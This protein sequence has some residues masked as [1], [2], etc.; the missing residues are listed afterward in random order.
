[1]VIRMRFSIIVVALNPGGKLNRTLESI[2]RQT[3]TDYEV[4]L[5]DGGSKD[6]SMDMWKRQA[7]KDAPSPG[8]RPVGTGASALYGEA[9]AGRV[10][11]FEEPDKGIYDAMNQAVSHARG[12]YILFLNC[13]D[14][15]ADERVLERTAEAIDRGRAERTTAIDRVRSTGKGRKPEAARSAAGRGNADAERNGEAAGAERMV[16]YGDTIGEKNGVVIAAAP[17]ITGF[18]CYRNI[19]C[20]QSCFYSADLCREKPYELEYKIRA[21]YDHFLWCFY[22]AGAKMIPLRFPVSSYEG[23]GYSESKENA[24]RDRQ[25]HKEITEQYMTKPA[26]LRYQL[27]MAL[28]LAPL[29][30][31]LAE[32]R[33][34][35]GV[36]HW[37]KESI[38]T[39]K[40]WFII[41]FILSLLEM[42]LMVWPIGWCREEETSFLAGEGSWILE[43]NYTDLSVCQEFRPQYNKLKSLGFVITAN[44]AEVIGGSVRILVTDENNVILAERELLYDQVVFDAYTD[45]ELDLLLSPR[46]S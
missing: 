10:R 32:N 39:R 18:T 2:F 25:E 12:E 24:R 13:G 34:L 41:A 44:E 43:G 8:D 30:R 29:R 27:I 20:H 45:V 17:E 38:Y 22:R 31:F 26:L 7:E 23:G 33:A 3:C 9:A 36:Y 28:T 42:A 1:M 46:D 35:S 40:H 5:K 37:V 6:G 4:V 11:F 14:L 16:F 19:P 15:F 21:D